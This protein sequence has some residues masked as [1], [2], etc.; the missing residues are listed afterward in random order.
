MPSP[1]TASINLTEWTREELIQR[2]R[3]LDA[4][5]VEL[6]SQLRE[7]QEKLAEAQAFL[8]ELQR[9]LF[10]S[11]AEKLSAEQ[12]KQLEQLASDI[13]EEAR[14]PPPLVQQVLEAEQRAKRRSR[15]RHPLPEALMM[16]TV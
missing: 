2:V 15:P 5:K 1:E 7:T 14:K 6:E 11:K 8:A 4:Q 16:S 13:R 3:E 10:G 12:E 9:Q